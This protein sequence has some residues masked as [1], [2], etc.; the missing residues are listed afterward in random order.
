MTGMLWPPSVP[1]TSDTTSSRPPSSSVID[2]GP[3]R[4]GMSLI[5]IPA[6]CGNYSIARGGMVET[7]GRVLF[8]VGGHLLRRRHQVGDRPDRLIQTHLETHGVAEGLTDG[9]ECVGF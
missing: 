9:S 4:N 3:V 6:A 2:C 5:W 8:H 1:I 7:A